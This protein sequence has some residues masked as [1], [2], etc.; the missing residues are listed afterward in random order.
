[1]YTEGC[2]QVVCKHY[3][4]VFKGFKKLWVL[5]PWEVLEPIPQ[6]CQSLCTVVRDNNCI[7]NKPQDPKTENYRGL[8]K[9][10]IYKAQFRTDL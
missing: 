5:D 9:H 1:M 8:M 2:V 7:L 4:S 6:G 3:I 10:K